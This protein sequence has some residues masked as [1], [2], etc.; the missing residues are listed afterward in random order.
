MTINLGE[1][2]RDEVWSFVAL[3]LLPDVARWRFPC[4]RIPVV[5]ID[6]LSE[7]VLR[8]EIAEFFKR[9]CVARGKRS[10]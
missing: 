9:A 4:K 3:D 10:A 8:Q 1:A 7:E 5:K 6:S 2:G